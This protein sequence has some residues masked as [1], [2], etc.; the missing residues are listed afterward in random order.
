MTVA[1]R[2]KEEIKKDVV[3]EL[4]WDGR[5][6]ASEIKVEASDD[7]VV[8]LTGTAPNYTAYDAADEDAWAISGVKNVKN[9]LVIKYPS[10]QIVHSDPEMQA[11]IENILLWHP[12][13]DATNIDVSVENS[14]VVLRGTV[15]S[16]WRKIRAEELAMGHS[17]VLGI[18]N[19]LGVVP[20]RKFEDKTIAEDIQSAMER[21]ISIDMDTIDIKDDKGKVTL[22]GT[23]PSLHALRAAQRISENTKGVLMVDNELLIR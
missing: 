14:W 19:E 2:T 4:Y 15:D 20:S 5:V 11:N 12:D 7:G 8:T 6:D 3:D 22:T 10:T 9:D 16:Y 17:G 21:N 1:T 13:M 23:V 18:T